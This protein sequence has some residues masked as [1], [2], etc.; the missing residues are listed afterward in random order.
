MSEIFTVAIPASPSLPLVPPPAANGAVCCYRQS[1][2]IAGRT[3]SHKVACEKAHSKREG[4]HLANDS[5][6]TQRR[7]PSTKRR[8]TRG[9]SASHVPGRGQ[10]DLRGR[11]ARTGS[12]FGSRPTHRA[13]ARDAPDESCEHTEEHGLALERAYSV[14]C[15]KTARSN[16]SSSDDPASTRT[17]ARAGS[18]YRGPPKSSTAGAIASL[19]TS[20]SGAASGGAGRS[21]GARPDGTRLTT[22]D[23]FLRIR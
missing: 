6:N 16:L 23:V 20:T 3:I 18:P 10:E 12:R 14:A 22:R 5:G 4:T 21:V 8:P 1:A 11:A 7:G 9:K 2:S 15:W 19:L 13:S 17:G